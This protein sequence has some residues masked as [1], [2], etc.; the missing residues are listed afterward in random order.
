MTLKVGNR[1]P[2]ADVS[3]WFESQ[4]IMQGCEVIAGPGLTLSVN[5]GKLNFQNGYSAEITRKMDEVLR[6][7]PPEVTKSYDFVVTAVGNDLNFSLIENHDIPI[8]RLS[9]NN[10]S[11]FGAAFSE[12]DKGSL[13]FD[14][15]D[16][17]AQFN[18]QGLTNIATI[19]M[20]MK[21][22]SRYSGGMPIGWGAYDVWCPSGAL[23]YNTGQGDCFGIPQSKVQSLGL[24]GNW[25]H[26]IF[27]MWATDTY[28]R[29]K[30]YINGEE[31]KMAQVF[32][33]EYSGNL[34]FNS[35]NGRFSGWF[36]SGYTHHYRLHYNLHRA[37][38]Y[39]RQLTYEE[40]YRRYHEYHKDSTADSSLVADFNAA[41]VPGQLYDMRILPASKYRMTSF[42]RP[43]GGIILARILVVPPCIGKESIF[44][45]NTLPH[46]GERILKSYRPLSYPDGIEKVFKLPV[47]IESEFGCKV[48]C[49]GV[50]QDEFTDFTIGVWIGED[51]EEYSS[52]VFTDAPGNGID[53]IVKTYIGKIRLVE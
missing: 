53:I 25:A 23:G 51:G 12:D 5:P 6:I 49:A 41:A 33:Q 16:D 36:A 38:I 20:V 46:K 11:V 47:K 44:V 4:G 30:I 40:K 34:N 45:Y 39:N 2:D 27:E 19:E 43:T 28:T 15:I 1:I 14:G 21:L 18:V 22:G 17:Y 29:N 24:V 7:V 42:T 37:R 10:A 9:G 32:T 50:P 13:Y 31:Q 35:G 8:E 26:Y 52:I 3:P 48:V